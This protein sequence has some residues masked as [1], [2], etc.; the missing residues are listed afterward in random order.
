MGSVYK[1]ELRSYFCNMQGAVFTGFLLLISGIMT[2]LYNFKG[3]YP[4]FEYTLSDTGFIFLLIV[5]IL[6]MR[7]IAEEKHGRTDKLLYALPIS[8]TDIIL[9]K[10]FALVTVFLVPVA[11]MGLYPI[12]LSFYGNV[13]LLS[14][15]SA[16]VGFVLLGCALLA[17]GMVL[18]SL[19]ESQVIAAVLSFGVLLLL[20]LMGSLSSLI[21]STAG[22]SLIAFSVCCLL[23]G[24]LVWYMTKDPWVGVTAAVLSEAVLL[25]FYFRAKDS[26]AGLFSSVLEKLSVFDRFT[27]FVGGLFDLTAVVYYL[28]IVVFCLFLCVQS[29]EKK[30]WN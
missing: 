6:T 9:G 10:Y 18:S 11:V 29:L 15:Y 30:R 7:V 23:L 16:L 21:P 24:L 13:S 2:V 25:F 28:S 12:V 17:I 3:L 8:V 27:T 4:N 19:T 5:P 22:A 20:Y 1:K 14:A 26:F